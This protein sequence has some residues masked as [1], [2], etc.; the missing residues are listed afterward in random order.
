M[1]RFTLMPKWHGQFC[2]RPTKCVSI[3]YRVVE[4]LECDPFQVI[5]AQVARDDRITHLVETMVDVYSFVDEAE[6]L[7]E[8]DTQKRILVQMAQQTMECGYFIRDYARN[9][10]FGIFLL[11]HRI[12]P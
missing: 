3:A 4:I 10:N 6:P 11:L 9:K 5:I 2:L 1:E 7:K 8:N 12:R